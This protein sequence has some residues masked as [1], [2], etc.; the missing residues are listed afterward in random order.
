MPVEVSVDPYFQLLLDSESV[1]IGPDGQDGASQVI[2]AGS[3]SLGSEIGRMEDAMAP[4]VPE[5]D[6]GLFS[7]THKTRTRVTV[8]NNVKPFELRI[9]VLPEGTSQSLAELK[10]TDQRGAFRIK[11]DADEKTK[12]P[13]YLVQSGAWVD[14]GL[15]GNLSIYKSHET[16]SDT[17][18]VSFAIIDLD[19]K[20]KAT[21]YGGRV[22][23]S[24]SSAL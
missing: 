20:T 24:L 7:T 1:R 4:P 2:S 23:W 9:S 16:V 22:L 18:N 15:D 14:F 12:H 8:L 6:G 17:F 11:V 13:E 3:I 10:S 19:P 21:Q 5:A